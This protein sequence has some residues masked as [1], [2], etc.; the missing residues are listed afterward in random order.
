MT[1]DYHGKMYLKWLESVVLRV[2]SP[3]NQGISIVTNNTKNYLKAIAKFKRV[4]EEN[5]KL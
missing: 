5:K 3:L 2:F 1:I 4:E